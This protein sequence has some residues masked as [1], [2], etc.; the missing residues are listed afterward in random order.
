MHTS[1]DVF[2]PISDRDRNSTSTVPRNR[3]AHDMFNPNTSFDSADLENFDSEVLA[4][5]EQEAEMSDDQI[6]YREVLRDIRSHHGEVVQ[7]QI[8]DNRG[9]WERRLA[10]VEGD[11]GVQE[12]LSNPSRNALSDPFYESDVTVDEIMRANYRLPYSL[13]IPTRHS[14][15]TAVA[16][17]IDDEEDF[18]SPATRAIMQQYGGGQHQR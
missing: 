8:T 2:M 13:A 10:L 16:R 14:V 12:A 11:Y 4:N 15:A 3:D 7:N 18:V 9:T 17:T 1:E 5:W 6:S